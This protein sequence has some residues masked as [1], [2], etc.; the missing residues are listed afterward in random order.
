MDLGVVLESGLD[1]SDLVLVLELGESVGISYCLL[2]K[3]NISRMA[4]S[5]VSSARQW[6]SRSAL[7]G[8]A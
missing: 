2:I 6:R 4:S 1:W 8:S 3:V 5:M 7:L